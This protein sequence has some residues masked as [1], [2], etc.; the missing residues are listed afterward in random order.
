MIG[1]FRVLVLDD[2]TGYGF[3]FDELLR[4]GRSSLP[5][6]AQVRAAS[7]VRE[8]VEL[9]DAGERFDVAIIDLGLGARQPSGLG[10][11]HVLGQ[12]TDT[13]IAVHTDYHEQTRRLLF[14]YAAFTWYD[15]VALLPKTGDAPG[16]DR[17][18]V[19]TDLAA[20]IAM[21]NR[22]QSPHPDLAIPFRARLGKERAFERI[23]KTHEDLDKWIAFVEYSN[24]TDVA[25]ALHLGRKTVE[26]WVRSKYDA[27]QALLN[28]AEAAKIDV[29]DAR[30][31]VSS[32]GRANQSVIH[33]FARSQSWFF[34]D[35]VVRD[36]FQR[37]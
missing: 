16:R 37:S 33:Q 5:G 35:P 32:L 36:R 13:R 25:R 4:L 8:V 1:H 14:L 18:A 24:I 31:N 30:V 12:R 28:D 11:I 3:A 34:T 19:A 7:S 21:I 23:L 20:K 17:A 15:P 10:A 22:G 26:N 29:T 9:I 2:A 6:P 27:T